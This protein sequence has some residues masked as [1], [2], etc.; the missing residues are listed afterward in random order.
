MAEKHDR[1]TGVFES[2]LFDIKAL[3]PFQGPTILK[4]KAA[5]MHSH[6]FTSQV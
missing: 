6:G 5:A 1:Q 4:A 2:L 3:I